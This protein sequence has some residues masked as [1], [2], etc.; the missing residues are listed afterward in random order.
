MSK[1][2]CLKIPHL[3]YQQNTVLCIAFL[4]HAY[5]IWINVTVVSYSQELVT[6]V[7]MA[8]GKFASCMFMDPRHM[9]FV[10]LNT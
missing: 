1:V 10:I 5:V 9:R 8:E 3:P 6:K 7:Y 4:D 2:C